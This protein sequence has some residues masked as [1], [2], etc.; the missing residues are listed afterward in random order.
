MLKEYIRLRY[1]E[2]YDQWSKVMNQGNDMQLIQGLAQAL[3]AT[4][5]DEATGQLKP[6]FQPEAESLQQLQQAVE[7]RMAQQPPP[8][9]GTKQG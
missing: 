8:Q 7:Q 2:K 9:N 4:V 1:P 3:Q 6:E 5:T